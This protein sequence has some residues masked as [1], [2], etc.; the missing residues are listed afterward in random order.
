[1]CRNCG[2][3]PEALALKV[4]DFTR[5]PLQTF[6]SLRGTPWSTGLTG[7]DVGGVRDSLKGFMWSFRGCRSSAT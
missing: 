6:R 2:Q 7:K 5:S 4:E 1:M 3:R